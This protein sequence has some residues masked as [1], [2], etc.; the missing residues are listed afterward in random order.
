MYKLLLEFTG[1]YVL[2]FA[3]H[4]A[5]LIIMDPSGVATTGKVEDERES[6]AS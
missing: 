2:H 4:Y 6:R 3:I 5:A 1:F